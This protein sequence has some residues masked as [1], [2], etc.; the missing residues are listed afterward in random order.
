MGVAA[1]VRLF[2]RS[3]QHRLDVAV[4]G[5]EAAVSVEACS[6]LC[7]LERQFRCQGFNYRSSSTSQSSLCHL[8]DKS[9]ALASGILLSPSHDYYQ[10]QPG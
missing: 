8:L 5:E 4:K 7:V 10:R 2:T 9:P 6:R 3:P 1:Y